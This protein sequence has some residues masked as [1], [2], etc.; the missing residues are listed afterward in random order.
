MQGAFIKVSLLIVLHAIMGSYYSQ[1]QTT[2]PSGY[3]FR[4]LCGDIL[5][6]NSP[7]HVC[8]HTCV[9]QV[10]NVV[11][12]IFMGAEFH[13]GCAVGTNLADASILNQLNDMVLT[14]AA[15]EWNLNPFVNMPYCASQAV[16]YFEINVSAVSCYRKAS[17]GSNVII[18]A[19]PTNEGNFV[20]KATYK[21]CRDEQ[22]KIR[23]TLVSKD[24]P[25]ANACPA[26]PDWIVPI[27]PFQSPC[28]PYCF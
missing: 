4:Q 1:A 22:L 6:N 9:R 17:D 8:V 7:C 23:K 20:C 19:C 26:A 10:G 12:V 27:G 18:S 25:P 24:P 3:Q 28:M 14:I 11:D 5:I 15:D 13:Q 16:S 21:V 2:C